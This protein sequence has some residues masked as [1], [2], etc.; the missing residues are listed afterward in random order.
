MTRARPRETNSAVVTS[1]VCT[2]S[3]ATGPNRCLGG[4]ST[5]TGSAS[6]GARPPW[7]ATADLPAMAAC[8]GMSQR[9]AASPRARWETLI[10]ASAY[11]PRKIRCHAEP[12]SSLALTSPSPTASR[13]ENTLPTNRGL[14]REVR[15]TPPPCPTRHFPAPVPVDNPRREG[16]FRETARI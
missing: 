6:A 5:S 16:S 8:A 12:R 3:P 2:R 13:A 10:R 14:C 11:T 9:T 1:A 15:D 7:N 4:T